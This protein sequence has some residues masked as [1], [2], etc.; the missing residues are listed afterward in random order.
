MS[1][2]ANN[3]EHAAAVPSWFRWMLLAG[4]TMILCSCSSPAHRAQRGGGG[5]GMPAGSPNDFSPVGMH[6]VDAAN[7]GMGGPV[8]QAGAS[9]EYGGGP[10]PCGT[11]GASSGGCGQKAVC[12][13]DG[14]DGVWPP[15]EWLYDGGDRHLKARVDGDWQVQGLDIEDTI[16]HYD[17]PDG[18]T[19]V[20]PSNCVPIYAPRFA[21]VRVVST[22]VA[23]LNVQGPQG[24]NLKLPPL[25]IEENQP[26][27]TSMQPIQLGRQ[28]GTRKANAF[29]TRDF[30]GAVS[31]VLSAREFS[32]VYSPYEALG[33]IQFGIL[34][35]EEKARLAKSV[36]NAI[37]W[38]ADQA[39]QVVIEGKKA[40]EVV[41]DEKPGVTYTIDSP[42]QPKLRVIKIASD[43]AAE[44]GDIVEFTIRFDNTGT[45]PMGNVTLLDNLTTRLEYLEGTAQASV[46]THE[47]EKDEQGQVV[48]EEREIERVDDNGNLIKS[49]VKIPVRVMNPVSFSTERNEADSVTLRWEIQEPLMPG[50]G[51]VLRFKCRV[52]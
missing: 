24:Q 49:T 18:R 7:M 27:A 32:D 50:Q 26:V 33:I 34:K 10:V 21:A 11:C 40:S 52:R 29:R 17:T 19:L 12:C 46:K 25:R 37:V 14:C 31:Q 41:K 36:Q 45:K 9:Y 39:V 6:P 2:S 5:P 51:G 38:T 20:E 3:A 22:A 8:M 1:H 35:Q 15:D 42:G 13:P 16:G 43:C 48:V 44:P 23:D 4:A 47:Y 28:I 30:A